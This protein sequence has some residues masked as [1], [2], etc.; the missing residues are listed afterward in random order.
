M[1][2][3]QQIMEKYPVGTAVTVRSPSLGLFAAVVSGFTKD[4]VVVISENNETDEVNHYNIF[5][6]HFLNKFRGY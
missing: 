2:I 4:K 1:D 6:K 3:K 5:P